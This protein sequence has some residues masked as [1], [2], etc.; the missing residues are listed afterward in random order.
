MRSS[1]EDISGSLVRVWKLLEAIQ[2]SWDVDSMIAQEDGSLRK[3]LEHF[4]LPSTH[5][6][7]APTSSA[8]FHIA[9]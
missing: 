6:C 5:F 3:N 9:N 4:A 1:N 2:T 7:I 8:K